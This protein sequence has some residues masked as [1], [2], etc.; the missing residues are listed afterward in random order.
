MLSNHHENVINFLKKSKK[1]P[2]T[3]L[4]D[5]LQM[6]DSELK[7]LLH[8]LQQIGLDIQLSNGLILSR[9]AWLST[10]QIRQLIDDNNSLT[11]EIY[12]TLPS[13]NTYLL[14]HKSAYTP[15]H[16]VCAEWQSQGRGQHDK[17]WHS[18]I[19]SSL[20]LSLAFRA[21]TRVPDSLAL[22]CAHW[23]QDAIKSYGIQKQLTIKR[24]ND[25]MYKNQKVAG[26][27][28]EGKSSGS[29]HLWVI[30]I[31]LNCNMQHIENTSIDQKWTDLATITQT[32]IDRNRLSGLIINAFMNH[33]SIFL[34]DQ[35]HD[36]LPSTSP[37]E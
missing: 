34:D 5:I 30:G 27:L 25:L 12:N 32:S 9:I 36:R 24:P 29:S 22:D 6:P 28:I 18:P 35:T 21:S 10:S 11:L 8:D 3:H 20:Y 15:Y 16:V 37:L 33:L 31:G 7:C 23:I 17:V 4:A 26:I 13:T 2:L 19:A 1:I 14:N